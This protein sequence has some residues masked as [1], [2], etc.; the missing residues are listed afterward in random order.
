MKRLAFVQP[1]CWMLILVCGSIA[2]APTAYAANGAALY[3]DFNGA[4]AGFG[5]PSG[6]IDQATAIWTTNNAG[7]AATTAY[8]SSDQLTVGAVLG[9]STFSGQTFSIA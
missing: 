3:I 5:A 4:T 1:L 8:V 7:T 6:T 2:T 9:D